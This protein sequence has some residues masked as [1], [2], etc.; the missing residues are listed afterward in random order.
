MAVSASDIAAILH[1]FN[2]N[3][4]N[5]AFAKSRDPYLILLLSII[6]M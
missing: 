4:D 3:G 1:C 5:V 2:A 6:D